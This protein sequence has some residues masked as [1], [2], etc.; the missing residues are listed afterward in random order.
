[1]CAALNQRLSQ[2]DESWINISNIS[3][4]HQDLLLH[5]VCGVNTCD[6]L[7]KK[8]TYYNPIKY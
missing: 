7:S 1:M 2:D 6:T 4:H 3:D 8:I 5:M